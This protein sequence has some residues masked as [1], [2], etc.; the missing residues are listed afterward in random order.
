MIDGDHNY[1]TVSGELAAVFDAAGTGH[2]LVVLHDIGW[3][4]ARRDLYYAPDALPP[5]SVHPHTYE[6]GVRP[7]ERSVG[8]GGF[9]GQGEFAYAL[10]EGG[11]RNGVLT[12]V[13]DFLT[14]HPSF[15][16]VQ[17]PCIFG[18]GFLFDGEA[19]YAGDLRAQ[20]ATYDENPL[21]ARLEENRIAL[22]LRV[23]DALAD[24]DGVVA[25]RDA[26]LAALEDLRAALRALAASRTVRT[27]DA[28][29]LRPGGG[30]GRVLDGLAGEAQPGEDEAPG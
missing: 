4:W 7:G 10:E 2:P 23:H 28:V 20:L 17:V 18:L 15:E 26:A 9:S 24:L 11:P 3:P 25:E 30:L 22:Y 29:T 27:F 5:G 12:A 21:L 6:G 19:P 16:L 14:D 1:E 8:P 13:E